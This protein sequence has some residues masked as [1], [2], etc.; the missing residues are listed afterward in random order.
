M[1]TLQA[2]KVKGETYLYLN[3]VLKAIIPRSQRQPRKD[4]KEI[5]INYFK[6]N[7]EFY[8]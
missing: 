3:N 1:K 6:Y 2:V 5:I 8:L 7:L 4:K